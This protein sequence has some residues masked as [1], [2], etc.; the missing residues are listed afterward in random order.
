M[1]SIVMKVKACWVCGTIYNLHKHHIVFG[2]G[3]R[4]VADKHG[5]WCW[6]CAEH[7][8]G[9]SGVHGGNHELDLALKQAAQTEFERNHSRD[10][11]RKLFTKSYL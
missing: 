2:R 9:F 11:W 8:E 4:S 3:Q 10:E 6:L 7:H 5:I 1:D